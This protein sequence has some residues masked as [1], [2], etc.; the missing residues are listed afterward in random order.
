M[1][2]LYR[3]YVE[4]VVAEA[5]NIEKIVKRYL[6]CFTVY[7][8]QGCWQEKQE[9]SLVIEVIDSK[10]LASIAIQACAAE[11]KALLKQECVL[12]TEQEIEARFV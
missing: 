9:A 8:A 4:D 3:I 11:L 6:D 2:T 1:S 10:P 7:H 5:S 12:V